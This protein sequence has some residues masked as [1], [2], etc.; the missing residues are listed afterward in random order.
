MLLHNKMTQNNNRQNIILK[1]NI[2]YKCE[3]DI[4]KGNQHDPIILNDITIYN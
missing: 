1:Q 4:T 2:D 3:F